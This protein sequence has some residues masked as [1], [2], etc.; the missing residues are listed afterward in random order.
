MGKKPSLLPPPSRPEQRKGMG[1]SAAPISA[2]R[3]S[4]VA[5]EWGRRERETREV[6]SRPQLERR[7]PGSAWPRRGAAAG[8]GR[9]CRAC[10]R[11][12]SEGKRRRRYWG[13]RCPHWLGLWRCGEGCPA[14]A[15]VREL[16][17]WRVVALGGR[18]GG[19]RWHCGQWEQRSGAGV[20]FIGGGV[21][22][23][24]WRLGGMRAEVSS[25]LCARPRRRSVY[26]EMT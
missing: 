4:G 21:E 16:R 25:A 24:R 6:D 22:L 20:L 12:G 10:R 8:M 17:L 11:P 19:G 14:M 23:G 15:G 1:A 5:P 2:A 18:G 3:G 26:G 7:W 13:S 9:R